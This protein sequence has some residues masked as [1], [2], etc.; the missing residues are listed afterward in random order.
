MNVSELLSSLLVFIIVMHICPLISTEK[1]AFLLAVEWIPFFC[2]RVPCIPDLTLN[3]FTT[4][5]LRRSHKIAS[6]DDDVQ[7]AVYVS[8]Y[9]YTG[10]IIM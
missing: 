5:S 9:I 8:P 7:K 1:V 6:S 10:L 4:R 2:E 3:K